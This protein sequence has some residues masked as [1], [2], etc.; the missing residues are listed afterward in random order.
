M[1]DH[2]PDPDRDRRRLPDPLPDG[3]VVL[4]VREPVGVAARPHRRRRPHPADAARPSASARYPTGR[5]SWCAR[6]AAARPRPWATCPA[7]PRRGQPRRRD[8]RV[9]RGRPPDGQR[10]R[11]AR[12]TSSDASPPRRRAGGPWPPAGAQLG[13]GPASVA[14]SVAAVQLLPHVSSTYL[15]NASTCFCSSSLRSESIFSM[16]VLGGVAVEVVDRLRPPARSPCGAS[17]GMSSGR[18]GVLEVLERVLA[19]VDSSRV[20]RL[21]QL[22]AKD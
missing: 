17:S 11:A 3:L 1:T 2:A 10:D 8:D 15:L 16:S 6:S 22:L 5:P 9:G 7:G 13:V 19:L 14:A 21:A 20:T 18:P 12:R 4:D